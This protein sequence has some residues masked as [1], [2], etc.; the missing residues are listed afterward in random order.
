MPYA[1]FTFDETTNTAMRDCVAR[2]CA[3]S[4]FVPDETPFHCPLVG[5]LHGYSQEAVFAAFDAAPALCAGRFL[6]W[7]LNASSQRLRVAVELTDGGAALLTHLQQAL[8][9]GKPWRTHY[10]TLGSVA[11]I[12]PSLHASFLAAVEAA[13]PIRDASFSAASLE[14]HVAAA[15]NKPPLRAPAPEAVHHADLPKSNAASKKSANN[16]DSMDVTRPNKVLDPRAK[17][18]VP[19]A[20]KAAPLIKKQKARK[21]PHQK[22]E[23]GAASGAATGRSAI[24]D[25]IKQ[26][27]S[28]G[29]TGART[30]KGRQGQEQRVVWVSPGV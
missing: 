21:S 9:Q 7:D 11:Q 6:N 18:F 26:S 2:I 12:E 22:W 15:T 14:F 3:T 5:S 16:K 8:P 4:A 19:S 13:F 28:T 17:P 29:S 30:A 27:G 10:V 24:D 20:P 1:C 23:R 25:L